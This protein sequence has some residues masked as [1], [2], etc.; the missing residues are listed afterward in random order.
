MSRRRLAPPAVLLA[1]ACL[2]LAAAAQEAAAPEVFVDEVAVDVVDLEV[3]VSDGKGQPIRG[4]GRDD[5]EIYED[6]Q[7]VELTNFYAIEGGARLDGEGP[8]AGAGG[9][10]EG[11]PALPPEQR[12]SLAVVIDNANIEPG[13]RKR[14]IGELR[15]HLHASLRPGDRVMLATLEPQ[16]RIR[17]SF[18]EDHAATDAALATLAASAAGRADLSTQ[19]RAIRQAIASR[20]GSS[21]VNEIYGDDDRR[22]ALHQDDP[23][24]A[25]D[26]TQ[27]MI[28]GFGDQIEA[29]TRRTF[30]SL[31]SLVG[32]LSGLPGR[33][34][35][36]FVSE[37]LSTQPVQGLLQEWYQQFSGDV[38][39]LTN[40]MGMAR[41]W[42]M[43][44]HLRQ[45]ALQAAA[46]RVTF[47]TLH[48]GGAFADLGGADMAMDFSQAPVGAVN[49]FER[50]PL[51]ELANVTGGSAMFNASNVRAL[52]E[53]MSADFH[54]YYSLGYVSP[55]SQDG[56][57]HRIEVRLA[58]SAAEG[59]R[60]KVRHTD[61]Y[62]AKTAE[63]R[64]SERTISALMFD[65]ADN[66]LGIKVQLLP[67]TRKDRHWVLPILVRVPISQLIL[68]PRAGEHLAR[69][70]IVVAVRDADGGLSTP[71]RVELPL[72]IPNDRLLDAM[73]QEIG[74]GVN[75]LVRSGDAKLAVGV[76]DELA[77]VDSTLNLNLS[78]GNAWVEGG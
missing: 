63:Q 32:S 26:R 60:A 27:D 30:G 40:P 52:L 50:E 14:V 78:V 77:A 42:D 33:R 13:S 25:A 6:G 54:D 68:L 8:V 4:L 34:A 11:Q 62:R 46:D 41:Q 21:G 3:V 9:E 23:G 57:F 72:R 66:P 12:L 53:R 22:Q 47:Y 7:R 16:I 2:T 64:M 31:G 69:V 58:A 29:T 65:V 19:R 51:A 56:E 20:D 36:L 37:H 17:Q 49:T 15:E 35:V 70:T 10:G 59:R 48:A 71:Q 74:H 75:L 5:F 28:R 43:T 73:S 67:E 76:R 61:G 55:K 38:E 18:T 45:V 39:G 44:D 1:I 24:E